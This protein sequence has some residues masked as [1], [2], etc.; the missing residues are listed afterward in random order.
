MTQW[1]KMTDE[2]RK[3]QME[4]NTYYRHK[5]KAAELGIPVEEYRASLSKKHSPVVQKAA[6]KIS[7]KVSLSPSEE[8][9]WEWSQIDNFNMPDEFYIQSELK[10]W[11]TFKMIRYQTPRGFSGFRTGEIL[12]SQELKDEYE[13]IRAL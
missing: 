13:S 3:A 4:R 12:I 6:K 10:P 7:K 2:Q 5:K 11:V 8:E 1:Q 9:D